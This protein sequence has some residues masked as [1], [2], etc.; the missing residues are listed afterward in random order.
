MSNHLSPSLFSLTIQGFSGIFKIPMGYLKII[1]LLLSLSFISGCYITTHPFKTALHISTLGITYIAEQYEESEKEQ[2]EKMA[3]FIKNLPEPERQ[4][5]LM[6]YLQ[7]RMM[8][9]YQNQ[10]ALEDFNNKMRNISRKYQ[11][12]RQ[13]KR[14][15][16]NL[17]P[18]IVGPGYSNQS[19]QGTIQEIK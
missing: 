15:Y 7:M 1:L 5:F 2:Q 17:Q 11:E 6:T 12:S 13:P 18:T 19:Y 14:Y 3:N 8:T 16:Y 9:N 10:I 4:Q